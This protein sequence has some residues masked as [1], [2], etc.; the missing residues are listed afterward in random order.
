MTISCSN[1]G[2][3]GARCRKKPSNDTRVASYT[4]TGHGGACC[5]KMRRFALFVV[6]T[7]SPGP[8]FHPESFF[9]D[10]PPGGTAKALGGRTSPKTSRRDF[11]PTSTDPLGPWGS[12]ACEI[13]PLPKPQTPPLEAGS[14]QLGGGGVPGRAGRGRPGGVIRSS[15]SAGGASRAPE[16]ERRAPRNLQDGSRVQEGPES[17]KNRSKTQDAQDGLQTAQDASKTPQEA[18]KRPPKRAPRG[19]NR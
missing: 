17:S 15:T 16:R 12:S 14:G 3:E 10:S 4:N 2:H 1:R 7:H 13:L 9:D 11:F 8:I 6:W 18:S 5:C 19:Q